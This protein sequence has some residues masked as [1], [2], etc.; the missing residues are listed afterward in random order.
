MKDYD[1]FL[2]KQLGNKVKPQNLVEIINHRDF[3]KKILVICDTIDRFKDMFYMDDENGK[4]F[5]SEKG[6]YPDNT[7]ERKDFI[8]I[9]GQIREFI[10]DHHHMY[11]K[12]VKV[13]DTELK[14][15]GFNRVVKVPLALG[16][17]CRLGSFGFPKEGNSYIATRAV[18]TS[19]ITYYI[20]AKG[21]WN[22]DDKKTFSADKDLMTI[23]KP[24]LKGTRKNSK[25][26][27]D[28]KYDFDPT[29]LK[30]TSIQIIIRS[31]IVS[32]KDYKNV[33]LILKAAKVIIDKKKE[34]KRI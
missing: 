4:K 18:I 10:K 12:L 6:N 31:L 13:S 14:E 27:K 1:G 16:E 22:K 33:E 7:P 28:E 11:T 3:K 8:R 23:F 15:K 25:T 9:R 32:V 30:I 17:L 26:K 20:S 24:N 19:L 5:T 29:K 34:K 21:L 2:E